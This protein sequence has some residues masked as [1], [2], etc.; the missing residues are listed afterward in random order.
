MCVCLEA[1]SRWFD[2]RRCVCG[3]GCVWGERRGV[4][5]G[6]GRTGRGRAGAGS[7]RALIEGSRWLQSVAASQRSRCWSRGPRVARATRAL[8]ARGWKA[9]GAPAFSCG[10]VPLVAARAETNA[11]RGAAARAPP[12]RPG[13][14]GRGGPRAFPAAGFSSGLGPCP[15]RRTEL[16]RSPKRRVNLTREF[17]NR[18]SETHL[19]P[20]LSGPT[21]PSKRTRSKVVFVWEVTRLGIVRGKTNARQRPGCEIETLKVPEPYKSGWGS[22]WRSVHAV[23][24][25]PMRNS[26]LKRLC[27]CPQPARQIGSRPGGFTTEGGERLTKTHVRL[28]GWMCLKL[29]TFTFDSSLLPFKTFTM[30]KTISV[31]ALVTMHLKLDFDPHPFPGLWVQWQRCGHRSLGGERFHGGRKGRNNP[32]SLSLPSVAIAF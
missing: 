24:R 25:E 17:L 12:A 23:C 4:E 1:V 15:R 5:G 19:P 28:K 11:G 13:E 10:F 18:G 20:L 29:L 8:S 26:A 14:G 30:L 27:N 32:L 7:G 2:K 9:R 22:A 21:S 16:S 31:R 6:G 3:G